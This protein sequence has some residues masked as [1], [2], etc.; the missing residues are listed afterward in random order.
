M[1]I[2]SIERDLREQVAGRIRLAA[3]GPDRFRVFTPFVLDDGD[4]LAIVLR[5]DDDGWMLSD[6]G[7]TYMRLARDIDGPDPHDGTRRKTVSAAAA[8][9]GIEDREGELVLG[10]RNDRYGDALYPFVQ[11]LLRIASASC[12]PTEG[13]R[14]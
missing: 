1:T 5:R 12:V 6:E 7:H 2:E 8:A 14:P 11:G 9:F 4:H 13:A 3:E 10:V